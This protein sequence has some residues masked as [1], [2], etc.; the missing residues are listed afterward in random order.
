[1]A[2]A[3]AIAGTALGFALGA[4]LVLQALDRLLLWLLPP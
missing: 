1:M 3:L 2:E 4:W